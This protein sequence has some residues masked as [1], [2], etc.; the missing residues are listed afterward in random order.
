MH[1]KLS[2]VKVKRIFNNPKKQ[3]QFIL[4]YKFNYLHRIL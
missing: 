1:V 3:L 2:T 4:N